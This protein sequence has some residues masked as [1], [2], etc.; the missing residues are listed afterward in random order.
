[1]NWRQLRQQSFLTV[2]I[3]LA[4]AVVAG[5]LAPNLS[6]RGAL[7]LMALCALLLGWIP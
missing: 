1:M 7:L 4:G 3:L 5:M 2:A 6:L